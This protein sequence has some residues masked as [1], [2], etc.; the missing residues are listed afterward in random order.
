MSGASWSV[1]SVCV[2]VVGVLATLATYLVLHG[3]LWASV[4]GLHGFSVCGCPFVC[5]HSFMGEEEHWFSYATLWLRGLYV[6]EEECWPY[7]C[8]SIKKIYVLV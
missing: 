4:Y 2:L 3:L 7:C 8:L 1:V 5:G 6:G